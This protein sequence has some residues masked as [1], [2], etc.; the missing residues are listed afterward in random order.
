MLSGFPPHFAHLKSHNAQCTTS[1]L[2]TCARKFRDLLETCELFSSPRAQIITSQKAM[3]DLFL[4]K[5]SKSRHFFLLQMLHEDYHTSYHSTRGNLLITQ[6]QWNYWNFLTTTSQHE[7]SH[8]PPASSR[9]FC[10]EFELL[11]L[12]LEWYLVYYIVTSC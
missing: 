3:T 4:N 11:V 8:E 7:A 6:M 10:F 12:L 1:Q 2:L 9:L 5:I